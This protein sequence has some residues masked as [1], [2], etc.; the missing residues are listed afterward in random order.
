VLSAVCLS[1]SSRT[2]FSGN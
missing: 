2:Y 1:I